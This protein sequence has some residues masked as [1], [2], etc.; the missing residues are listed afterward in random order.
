MKLL[1]ENWRKYNDNPF[2]LLCEQYD[3]KNI[4]EHQLIEYWKQMTLKEL[5]RLDEIDW[6]KEAELTADPDYKP[7]QERPRGPGMLQKGWEK[8]NDWILE[9][10]VQ[11]IDLAKRAG[12][13]AIKSIAWLIKKIQGFCKNHPRV[14]KVASMTL[15]VIAFYI[16][17]TL[18]FESE[19]QA[20]LTRGGK[21]VSQATVD[22]MKGQLSDIID[23]TDKHSDA[24]PQMHKLLASID[25]LHNSETKHDFQ[26]SMTK[27]DKG[28]NWLYNG[29]VDTV[30]GKGEFKDMDKKERLGLFERWM[31]IGSRTKAWYEEIRSPLGSSLKYGKSLAKR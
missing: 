15:A 9:K 27:I 13:A 10:S 26:E 7:P 6:E 1:I 2:Q 29:L 22:A 20:K 16:V 23:L 28:L 19:A 18:L 24:Q 5:E 30:K 17:F 31:D 8:V 4:N 25:E 3:K 14:C 12:L 11:L 21:P